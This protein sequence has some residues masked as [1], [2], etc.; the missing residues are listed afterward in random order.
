V[1][2]RT[3]LHWLAVT[4]ILPLEQRQRPRQRRAPAPPPRTQWNDGDSR[5]LRALAV[6]V[7]PSA[8][9]RGRQEAIADRFA[10]WLKN[11]K[12]GADRGHGY[13]ITSLAAA[14]DSP[15]A[16]YIAQLA[17][18]DKA[19]RQ[20]GAKTFDQLSGD[21]QRT[22]IEGSF[23]NAKVERLPDR[24]DGKHV[25]ADLMAFFFRSSAA[26]D[27]CYRAEIGRDTCR[28]LADSAA[29]PRRLDERATSSHDSAA[30]T[31]TSAPRG[32]AGS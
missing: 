3:L 25:A 32:D 18:L 29:A 12:P 7:L 1:L 2:R 22:L 16:A 13:G 11:Y 23:Q 6:A 26:N 9:G 21:D 10:V 31:A 28:D 27:L 24:P 20:R 30:A 4:G 5:L 19:A 14:P 8:L 15:A 17:V